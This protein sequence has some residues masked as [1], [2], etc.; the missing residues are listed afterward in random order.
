MGLFWLF[1]RAKIGF[2]AHFFPLFWQFSRPFSK[3]LAHSFWFFSRVD[4]KLSRAQFWDFSQAEVFFFSVT[5]IFHSR[6][7]VI[8]PHSTGRKPPAAFFKNRLEERPFVVKKIKVPLQ[9]QIKIKIPSRRDNFFIEVCNENSHLGR[10]PKYRKIKNPRGTAFCFLF[11]DGFSNL[12]IGISYA[13]SIVIMESF[14]F[15]IISG[16]KLRFCF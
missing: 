4:N 8:N 6:L 9:V 10:E 2:L 11:L 16:L 5:L 15:L 7:Y 13:G 3:F 12:L 1:S 14:R